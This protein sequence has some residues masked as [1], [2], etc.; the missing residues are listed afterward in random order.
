MDT[1]YINKE[2]NSISYSPCEWC[3][4]VEISEAQKQEIENMNSDGIIE[5]IKN[6]IKELLGK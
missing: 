2:T 1:V 4:E 6:K 3:E 5:N